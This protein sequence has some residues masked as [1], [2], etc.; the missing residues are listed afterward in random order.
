M[1]IF[2]LFFISIG[3]AMDAFSVALCKGLSL[4]K[5]GWRHMCLVG[6]YFGLFQAVMPALGYL[7]G[8][9]LSAAIVRIDHW[10]A[11][12]LLCVIG[13]SML[14]EAYKERQ[15][16]C[17]C[18]SHQCNSLSHKSLCMAA[19]ATSIDALAVGV[20]FAFLDV[21]ILPAAGCIGLVAMTLSM[22]GVKIGSLFGARYKI[23]AQIAGGVILILMGSKILIEHIGG[24]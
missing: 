12:F 18:S 4:N 14:R 7:I 6:G 5:A 21:P 19:V 1:G 9:R 2:E 10:I 3:L 11:F 17:P 23:K 13:A 16:S 24:F 8:S 22:L 15:N 20:S